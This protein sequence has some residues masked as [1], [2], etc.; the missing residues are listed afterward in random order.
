MISVIVCTY[1]RSTKL[2]ACLAN[3]AGVTRPPGQEWELV[4]VD[5]NSNDSTKET[6]EQFIITAPISVRYVFEPVQ[7]KSAALNHGINLAN[8]DIIAITDDDCLVQS[9]WL[10]QITKE[11]ERDTRLDYMGGRVEL[12]NN[13]DKPVS[14]RTS[15]ERACVKKIGEI[16]HIPGC[17]MAFRKE[18]FD[19]IGPFDNN[20]GPGIAGGTTADDA[21][22]I[23]R[24]FKAGYT[25]CYCPDALVYHAHSRQTDQQVISLNKSYIKGRAAMY[26]KHALNG[27][28]IM[29]KHLYWELAAET[30]NILRCLAHGQSVK[31]QL[32][33][34]QV[35]L[36][37]IGVAVNRHILKIVSKMGAPPP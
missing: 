11:F 20:F 9:D 33:H 3:L 22:F 17:N 1:N 18:V 21:D 16:S 15:R 7:G 26:T 10:V 23:Y 28:L 34:V 6:I 36:S 8:G 19:T 32:Q 30:K 37:G 12:A 29:C 14:I 13:E 5:N 27:D 2:A 24:A 4:V 31:T 25:L 35:F